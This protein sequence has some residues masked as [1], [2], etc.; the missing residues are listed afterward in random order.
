[1]STYGVQ[2]EGVIDDRFFENS[3]PK[4]RR[5]GITG[6]GSAAEMHLLLLR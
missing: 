3:I 4:N 2:G 6:G 1:M 5:F